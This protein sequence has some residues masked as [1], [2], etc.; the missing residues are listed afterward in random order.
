MFNI[1]GFNQKRNL[2]VL[3][4]INDE[5]VLYSS[6]RMWK[7]IHLDWTSSWLKQRKANVKQKMTAGVLKCLFLVLV[8]KCLLVHL[9]AGKEARSLAINYNLTSDNTKISKCVY[10]EFIT[11]NMFPTNF[12]YFVIYT[13]LMLEVAIVDSSFGSK[14]SLVLYQ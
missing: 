13:I 1:T 5:K 11:M 14:T 7:R 3:I 12:K 6:R 2:R 9:C 10:D 8:H 4:T